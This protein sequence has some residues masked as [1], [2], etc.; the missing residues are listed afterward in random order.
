MRRVLCVHGVG[1]QHKGE[2]VL[3]MEW[4][5]ALR[6]GI[7]RARANA[8]AESLAEAEVGCAFYGDVLRQ[9]G[10][11][12]ALGVPRLSADDVTWFGRELLMAWWQGAAEVDRG[13][14]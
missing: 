12:L 8:V 10:R 11:R 7:R 13:V 14:V 2:D 9:R 5:P 3:R 1:Q 4:V 6:D